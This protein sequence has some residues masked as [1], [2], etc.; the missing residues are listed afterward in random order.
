MTLK[1][2]ART[3]KTLQRCWLFCF[4]LILSTPVAADLDGYESIPGWRDLFNG[5]NLEGWIPK[6]TGHAL[7]ENYANTFRVEGGL[8]K[9]RYD[10]YEKFA[11][12]FGHLFF[13]EAFS[14]YVLHVEYRFVGN[15]APGGPRGW[16]VRNSGVML[17]SQK[18]ATMTLDQDFPDS[19]EAQFL[20][21]LSDGKARPT[22]NLCTPG[23]HVFLNDAL[24]KPHCTPSSAATF[25]GDQWVDFM[26]IVLGHGRF[27]HIV[28]GEEVLS[29]NNP[30]LDGAEHDDDKKFKLDR[31]YLALQSESHPID[32][33]KVRILSLVGCTDSTSSNYQPWAIKSSPGAC[34]P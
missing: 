9:V 13:D 21:G 29:Y 11:N 22:A 24:F 18:P 1:H 20:G 19:I 26:V 23:T 30:V 4:T 32:F 17:H 6:I 15:Q 3:L 31:G 25:D 28:N 16:A 8:L 7:A 10:G 27:R 2:A 34:A 12:Q 5:K 33:R 14:H